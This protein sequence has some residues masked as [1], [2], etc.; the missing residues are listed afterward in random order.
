MR[1]E[2]AVRIGKQSR[3][4][5][6]QPDLASFFRTSDAMPYELWSYRL[7]ALHLPIAHACMIVGIPPILRHVPDEQS[8]PPFIPARVLTAQ[9]ISV[10]LY[11]PL[12]R[13]RL[14]CH[15][16]VV[17]SNITSKCRTFR[18]IG[19]LKASDSRVNPL[20][21]EAQKRIANMVIASRSDTRSTLEAG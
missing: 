10:R 19:L 8:S 6:P 7:F 11:A 1:D 5:N 2:S 17:S 18:K 16:A 13:P 14:D 3:Y 4:F 21:F 9:C 20:P 15:D 12:T